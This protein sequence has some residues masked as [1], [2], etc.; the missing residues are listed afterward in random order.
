MTK[1]DRYRRQHW[2]SAQERVGFPH[3]LSSGGTRHLWSGRPVWLDCGHR[4]WGSWVLWRDCSRC[5]CRRWESVAGAAGLEESSS[6]CSQSFSGWRTHAL[7]G[8]LSDCEEWKSVEVRDWGFADALVMMLGKSICVKHTQ[9][10]LKMIW[11]V[12]KLHYKLTFTQ[13]FYLIWSNSCNHFTHSDWLTINQWMFINYYDCRAMKVMPC[14]LHK[15]LNISEKCLETCIN[16]SNFAMH[17]HLA[18]TL[19]FH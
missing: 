4:S 17:N 1:V 15:S 11:K 10:L 18:C 7:S 12:R 19:N 3:L 6:L 2:I 13:E 9:K 5:C 14:L 8:S 16:M